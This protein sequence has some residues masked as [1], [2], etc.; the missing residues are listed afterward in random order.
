VVARAIR[1]RARYRATIHDELEP[2]LSLPG[3]TIVGMN[4]ATGMLPEALTWYPR[5]WRVK[6]GLTGAQLTY[7][8]ERLARAPRGDLRVLVTHH[9]VVRGRLSQ[10]W[11]LARPLRTLDA[12][13]Q[14]GAHVVC[15]GHDHEERIEVVRHGDRELLVCTANTLSSRVRGQRASALN[16]VERNGDTVRATAWCYQPSARRFEPGDAAATLRLPSID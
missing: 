8:A 1:S 4:S 13:A 11:G 15:T 2:T 10:R 14:M 9:N 6:G 7:A 16:V 12:I 5:D 3:V